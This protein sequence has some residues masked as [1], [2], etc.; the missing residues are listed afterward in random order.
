MYTL[1]YIY[2]Y[3]TKLYIHMRFW[4][5]SPDPAD[6]VSSTATGGL[7]STRAGGQDEVEFKTKF[8]K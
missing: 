7:P 5:S 4:N 8:L 3:I 2:I 6:Q 1:L